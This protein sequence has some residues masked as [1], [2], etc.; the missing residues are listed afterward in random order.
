MLKSES[1]LGVRASVTET[2]D[3]V[4]GGT[5]VSGG[6]PRCTD[7]IENGEA[8]RWL[9]LFTDEGDPV[10]RRNDVSYDASGTPSKASESTDGDGWRIDES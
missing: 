2:D 4:R 7:E 8:G 6:K 9:S 5:G 1:E 10:G 3:A